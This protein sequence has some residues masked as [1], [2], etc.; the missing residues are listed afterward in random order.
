MIFFFMWGGC[1]GS[2][3]LRS[4]SKWRKVGT[5]I[6]IRI[7]RDVD[8]KHCIVT[9]REDFSQ[10]EEAN[11]QKYIVH[12]SSEYYSHWLEEFQSLAHMN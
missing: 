4:G 3:S 5:S 9:S 12:V 7:I 10:S 6:Q 8:P 1:F 11:G 2:H